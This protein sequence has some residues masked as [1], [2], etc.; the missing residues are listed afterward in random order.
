MSAWFG[1]LK[2]LKSLLRR[3]GATYHDA[4]DLVQDAFLRLHEYLQSGA[5]VRQPHSFLTRT[6]LNLA[7]DRNRSRSRHPTQTLENVELI[8][9][10]ASLEEEFDARQRLKA[11][12][13]ILDTK[14][15]QR[16]RTIYYLHR[17]EGYT[18]TEIA[19]RMRLS[20]RTVE[21]EV[22]RVLTQLWM[23]ESQ[24]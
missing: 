16:A 9:I 13:Q 8:D 2:K 22:A 10:S 24:L 14:V 23:E 5:E 18:H 4:E 17:I 3:H 15:S 6:A 7:I 21:K 1:H 11:I 20:V 12:T 19:E